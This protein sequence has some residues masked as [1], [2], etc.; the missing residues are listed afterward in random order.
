MPIEF[1]VYSYLLRLSFIF[2]NANFIDSEHWRNSQRF[3]IHRTQVHTNIRANADVT[4]FTTLE[5]FGIEY[6]STHIR[7]SYPLFAHR[8]QACASL[9]AYKNKYYTG[10]LLVV[11]ISGT[12]LRPDLLQSMQRFNKN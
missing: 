2:S 4:T 5:Y 10:S 11:M 1:S 6:A 3:S 7:V 12:V 9:N 8:G